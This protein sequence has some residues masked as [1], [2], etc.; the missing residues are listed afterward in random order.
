[1]AKF[2]LVTKGTGGDLFP[3]LRIGKELLARGHGAVV[4]SNWYH[5]RETRHAGL[6]FVPLDDPAEAPPE[7]TLAARDFRRQLADTPRLA[8]FG[9]PLSKGVADFEAIAAQCRAQDAVLVSNYITFLAARPVAEKLGLPFAAVFM[10]PGFIPRWLVGLPF[11]DEL[12]E[13][14]GGD[15]NRIREAVGLPPVTDWRAWLTTADRLL[16]MWPEWFDAARLGEGLGI[17]PVGFAWDVLTTRGGLAREV[18]DFLS[19]GEPPVLVCHGTSLPTRNDFFEVAAEACAR[20]GR[21]AV[22][23]TKYEE[24]VPPLPPGMRWFRYAAFG[25]LMPLTGAVIHHA[26]IGTAGQALA[27]GVPQLTLHLGHDREGTA[28]CLRALGVAET[29]SPLEWRPEPVAAALERL[30]NSPEV[31]L[32]CRALSRRMGDTESAAG[33]C[34]QLEG[35]IPS[36]GYT[37][38]VVSET[39]ADERPAAPRDLAGMVRDLDPARRAA[40]ARRLKARLGG[41]RS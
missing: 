21:R 22:L 31:R 7:E 23:V 10:S 11:F 2:V 37:R 13:H 4:L 1:M 39:A 25:E 15:L 27:A 35:L 9:Q 24:S 12:Y 33:I 14:V 41:A 36:R 18:R 38:R 3:F 20:A 19:A 17:I 30:S 26:G 16:G 8:A 6:D 40:L 5:G 29:L 28:A 32:K 34:E